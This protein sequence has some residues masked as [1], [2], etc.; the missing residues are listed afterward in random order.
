MVTGL[1]LRRRFGE[2]GPILP[3]RPAY[4]LAAKVQYNAGQPRFATM[5]LQ[6]HLSTLESAGL[7]RLAA[8]QPELEYLFRHALVQEAAY[9]SILKAD[10][11]QLHWQV[12]QALEHAYSDRLDEL[13]GLLA[14]HYSRAEAWDMALLHARP[15]ADRA[16]RL[17]ANA[18][19]LDYYDQALQALRQLEAA[20]APDG[21]QT[22][23]A[24]RFDVLSERHGVWTLIGQFDRARADLEAMVALARQIGDDQRLS[25]A[26]NGL[27][28]HYLN[29]GAGDVLGTLEE[30]LAVKRRLG[31]RRGQADSLNTLATVYVSVGKLAEG[32]TAA[33]EAHA[34]YAALQD[35]EGLARNE[36]TTGLLTYEGIGH[37][38]RALAHFEQALALSRRVGHRP[39]ECGSLLMLGAAN[40]RSGDYAAGR[41]L[42]T[43]TLEMARRIGD[44]PAEGWAM[45]YESW[46]DREERQFEASLRRA[47]AALVNGRE[48]GSDNLIWYSLFSLARL[49]LAWG[50]A[51]EALPLA[52]Q[53][54]RIGRNQAL[55]IEIIPR[56]LAVLARAHAELGQKDEARRYALEALREL[57]GMGGRGVAEAQELY[58]ACYTALRLAGAPEAPDVLKQAHAAMTALAEAFPDPERRAR[59]LSA[60][61][62]N[63]EIAA[64][65][66]SL[67]TEK[68][69][70]K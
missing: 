33:A 51:G 54:N 66:Q 63:R 34:L 68:A 5:T 62:V 26:L 24:Q 11:R 67:D 59:F 21:R 40:V 1:R 13:H 17:Y 4:G 43:Q 28:Y 69:E 3:H 27:G 41:A 53:T 9:A 55:W 64:A 10:R 6:T 50:R 35:A 2:I 7:V 44:R 52:D 14:Y 32:M 31:D 12:G 70:M 22:L 23:L 46:A 65:W 61:T 45:L 20:R 42:L 25:D 47:E 49:Y 38:A 19:A 60:V 39:L 37:Y 58:Y 29:I 57:Q 18:E 15:A 48:S 56:G 36:W 8:V 30:A 16:K